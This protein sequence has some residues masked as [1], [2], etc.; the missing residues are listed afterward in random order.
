MDRVRIRLIFPPTIAREHVE[1]AYAGLEPFRRFNALVEAA[2]ASDPGAF[3]Q[4]RFSRLLRKIALAEEDIRL[5]SV[6][7]GSANDRRTIFG[8]AITPH[9]MMLSS[10]SSE[11]TLGLGGY[12]GAGLVSLS[13]PLH[14]EEPNPVIAAMVKYQA[15]QLL[16]PR[17]KGT[18]PA[19][20]NPCMMQESPD[21]FEFVNQVF[22]GGLDFCGECASTIK[23][24]I[25][26]LS[27]SL[28]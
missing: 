18:A 21:F 11:T 5:D 9:H 4:V 26:R 24:T 28:N 14:L 1:A 16:F 27:T 25:I 19:C 13:W 2:C 12:L 7:T 23:S 20:R 15:G 8:I 3:T 10:D 22:A 17:E 6:M